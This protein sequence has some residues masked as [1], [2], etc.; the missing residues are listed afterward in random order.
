MSKRGSLAFTVY[1][2]PLIFGVIYLALTFLFSSL[3]YL[4][5]D[6]ISA[7]P[8]VV[9]EYVTVFWAL[10]LII[11]FVCFPLVIFKFLHF[12][13]NSR[14]FA[15]LCMILDAIAVIYFAIATFEMIT[16]FGFS[17]DLIFT[18]IYALLFLVAFFS[19]ISSFSE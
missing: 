4:G 9:L 14:I 2:F 10:T 15:V 7:I 8:E 6:I 13:L 19:E 11:G 17:I 1:L 3:Q 18:L 5:V 12:T 16:T